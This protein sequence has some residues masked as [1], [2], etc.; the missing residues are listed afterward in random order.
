MYGK[1]ATR[2]F[3]APIPFKQYPNTSGCG[4]V[5]MFPRNS[6]RQNEALV[7]A[8]TCKQTRSKQQ[9]YYQENKINK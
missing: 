9:T 3:W 7:N 8:S 5:Y 1:S 4:T 6:H 2:F